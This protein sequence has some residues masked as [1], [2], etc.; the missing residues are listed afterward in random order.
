[1]EY[2]NTLD[3]GRVPVKRE[4]KDIDS[5]KITTIDLADYG[6]EAEFAS[7]WKDL[8][9]NEIYALLLDDNLKEII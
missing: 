9:T 6:D 8:K 7:I 3:Y 1:M 2:I 4:G 5:V